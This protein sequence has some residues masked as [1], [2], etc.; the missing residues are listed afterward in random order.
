[1]QVQGCNFHRHALY[2]KR[3]N[4]DNGLQALDHESCFRI[5]HA[6]KDTELCW[7]NYIKTDTYIQIGVHSNAYIKMKI[8]LSNQTKI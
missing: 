6:Y 7:Q 1:M 3:Q 2:N 5:S 4:I 8:G